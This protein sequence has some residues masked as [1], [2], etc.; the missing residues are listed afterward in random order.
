LYIIEE[1]SSIK[2]EIKNQGKSEERAGIG[3]FS[4]EPFELLQPI[5]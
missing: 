2:M 4:D 3:T 1:D 5:D